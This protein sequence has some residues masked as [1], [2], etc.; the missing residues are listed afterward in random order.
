MYRTPHTLRALY[1]EYKRALHYYY[2]VRCML[3]IHRGGARGPRSGG[4]AWGRN[5]RWKVRELRG[6]RR[7]H[8]N[9]LAEHPRHPVVSPVV[10]IVVMAMADGPPNLVQARIM[11]ALRDGPTLGG[12]AFGYLWAGLPHLETNECTTCLCT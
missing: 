5:R 10:R 4:G 11:F 2:S 6:A 8:I 9:R 3:S 12:E 7:G 1:V